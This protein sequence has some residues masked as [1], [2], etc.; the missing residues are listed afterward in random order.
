MTQ[1][2]KLIGMAYRMGKWINITAV[3]WKYL[4]K[5]GW[6]W[7]EWSNGLGNSSGGVIAPVD[8]SGNDE[9]W[10]TVKLFPP[11]N[12]VFQIINEKSLGNAKEEQ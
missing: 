12:E 3:D 1:K 8:C 10:N 9:V 4:E 5:H 11:E 7:I 2:I 6:I